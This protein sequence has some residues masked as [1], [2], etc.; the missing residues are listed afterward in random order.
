VKEIDLTTILVTTYEFFAPWFWPIL[1]LT[2]LVVLVYAAAIW[3]GRSLVGLIRSGFVSAVVAAVLFAAVMF[4]SVP[5]L[6]SSS[7]S[8]V[9]GAVDVFFIALIALGFGAAMFV[10]ALP[11]AALFRTRAPS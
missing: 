5:A 3:R 2:V 1:L 6:T 11:V 10:T 9:G 7:W 4:A 8:Y